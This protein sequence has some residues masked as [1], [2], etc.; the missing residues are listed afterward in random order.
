CLDTPTMMRP[1]LAGLYRFLD[2]PQA[3]SPLGSVAP[4][5]DSYY[6]SAWSLLRWAMDHA[7]IDEASFTRAL[8]TS[9]QS[10]LANLEARAGRS[11]DEI[12]ARWSLATI[13]DGRSG[14]EAD[15]PSL[16]FRGWQLGAL[17]EGFCGDL[18]GCGGGGGGGGVNGVFGRAHPARLTAIAG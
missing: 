4:G 16:R 2:A 12:L 10:G 9:G 18:G 3:H 13:T 15:D 14:L 6:G 5:D 17:F 1:A 7:A 8:S 11:W